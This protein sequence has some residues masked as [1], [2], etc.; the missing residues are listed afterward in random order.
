M[1][2]TPF[3]ISADAARTTVASYTPASGQIT[4]ASI[5]ASMP[6]PTTSAPILVSVVA[7][8]TYGTYPET[9]GLYLATGL[10][11]D[12]LTG[13][14]LINGVDD[15]WAAGTIVEMRMCAYLLNLIT[16]AV[17][18][19]QTGIDIHGAAALATYSLNTT[20]LPSPQTG[21]VLQL[22]NAN[23]TPTRLELDSYGST[24]YFSAVVAGGTAASP[25]ALTSGTEL[26]GFNAWGHDGSAIVGPRA[27][28]RIWT[29][30]NWTTGAQGTYTDITATLN[31]ATS[32]TQIVQFSNGSGGVLVPGSVTG[33]DMG[34]GMVNAGGVYVNGV[35]VC[36]P[37]YSMVSPTT[38]T[39]TG[40]IFTDTNAVGSRSLAAGFLNT[41]GRTIRV[42][43]L[44]NRNDRK[45]MSRLCICTLNSIQIA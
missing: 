29:N 38:L 39:S 43:I 26:G 28:F 30:Q 5:P 11:G 14:T 31:G 9:L 15:A 3:P 22:A 33:G 45:L 36:R 13:L 27:S 21:S 16:A 12:T 6:T 23:S 35:G 4:L 7:T 44:G 8:A 1:S 24:S 34:A 37:I 10:T 20:T 32:A 18:A 40:S 25:T 42:T 2:F 17:Y 41:L 19:L